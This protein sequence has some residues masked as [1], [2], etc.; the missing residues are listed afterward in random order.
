MTSSELALKKD[1]GC[2]LVLRVDWDLS[3]WSKNREPERQAICVQ[4]LSFPFI[5]TPF[6][7]C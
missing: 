5:A 3:I 6:F 4:L 1:T 7:V 2:T